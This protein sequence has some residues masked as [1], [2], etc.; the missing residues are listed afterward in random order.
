MTFRRLGASRGQ[1]IR[2]GGEFVNWVMSE[3]PLFY[4]RYD[5][6]TGTT[7]H[8][9]TA[10]GRVGALNGSNILL[11]QPSLVASDPGSKAVKFNGGGT[12]DAIT[13][14]AWMNVNTGFGVMCILSPGTTPA[15]AGI[16]SRWQ[17]ANGGGNDWLLWYNTS[18]FIEFLISIGGSN[19]AVTGSSAAPLN[20]PTFFFAGWDGT[21]VRLYANG[22]QVSL[23]AN[24]TGTLSVA[25]SDICIGQYGGGFSLANHTVD[26]VAVFD[27]LPSAGRIAQMAQAMNPLAIAS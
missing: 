16:V 27:H 11:A 22:Q 5:E 17:N 14:A 10:N 15:N 4:H 21:K 24:T 1:K 12:F 13:S 25:A 19:Y 9:F 23:S 6:A 8:D 7:F 3:N 26:E 2:L 20:V 18:G